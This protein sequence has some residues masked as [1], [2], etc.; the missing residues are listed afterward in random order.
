MKTVDLCTKSS[1][2]DDRHYSWHVK[3]DADCKVVNAK[4]FSDS[5]HLEELFGA[6]TAEQARDGLL[7]SN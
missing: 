3:L 2:S 7:K 5:Q 6:E 1:I 4:A